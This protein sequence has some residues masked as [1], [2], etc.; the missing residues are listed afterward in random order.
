MMKRTKKNTPKGYDSWYE[1][2]FHALLPD[3]QVHAAQI[4]YVQHRVYHPDFTITRDGAVIHVETKGR[5]RDAAEARKYVDV[6]RALPAN[7][8]LVFCF[9]RGRK[10]MPNSRPRKDGTRYCHAE[11]AE[12]NGFRWFELDT[13]KEGLGL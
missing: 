7:T 1:F 11:W 8:E 10:P 12:N 2:D 4:D 13:I 5:F 9:V 6:Q 3:A